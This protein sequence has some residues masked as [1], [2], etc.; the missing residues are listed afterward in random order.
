MVAKFKSGVA[1]PLGAIVD[2]DPKF[3]ASTNVDD[4]GFVQE[5]SFVTEGYDPSLEQLALNTRGRVWGSVVDVQ[6]ATGIL[7]GYVLSYMLP[8]GTLLAWSNGTTK[9][10]MRST[11][12]GETWTEVYTPTT[13]ISH[14]AVLPSGRIIFFLNN[15]NTVYISD[16][17]GATFTPTV[18]TGKGTAFHTGAKDVSSNG[19]LIISDGS[20]NIRRTTDG[21]TYTTSTGLTAGSSAEIINDIA[22]DGNGFWVATKD[23]LRLGF[24]YDDGLTW[25]EITYN[26]VTYGFSAATGDDFKGVAVGGSEIIVSVTGDEVRS[27]F[28][29]VDKGVTW[30]KYTSVLDPLMQAAATTPVPVEYVPG[31]GFIATGSD[32]AQIIPSLVQAIAN[33]TPN[34]IL[35]YTGVTPSPLNYA[36]GPMSFSE[37]GFLF[38][39]KGS[40]TEGLFAVSKKCIGLDSTGNPSK[41]VR[42]I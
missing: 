13:T 14:P 35:Y 17:D 16:D 29:S 5:G 42:Y 18:T 21:V 7:D 23:D 31:V 4:M 30:K 34:P 37:H 15:S 41:Y 38:S 19:T 6:A 32:Y 2:F 25:T 3:G 26:N 9:K 40:G 1:I 10:I 11:D 22:T 20:G 28:I 27:S 24:S 12:M 8:T 39:S 33:V 36:A